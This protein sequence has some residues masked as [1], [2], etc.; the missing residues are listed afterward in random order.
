MKTVVNQLRRYLLSILLV[1]AC[2]YVDAQS[3]APIVGR[4]SDVKGEWMIGVSILEKGTSN[5]VITDINGQYS[6]STSS[7]QPTLVFR[8]LVINSGSEDRKKNV[9]DIVL[10]E[11][12]SALDE[13]VVVGYGAQRKVSVVGSQSSIK[14]SDIKAATGDISSAIAGRIPG[15]VTIQRSGEPGKSGSEIWIRGISTFTS[16]SPLVLVDGVERTFNQL[17]PE[18]IES[19]TILKDASATAVYGVRGC[20]WCYFDKDKAR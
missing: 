10:E 11:D 3:R 4:V 7:A 14:M 9:V 2:I 8:I 6:I 17:D 20:E 19:F 18:D 12:V 15:V 5:G 16:S 13:V 1:C